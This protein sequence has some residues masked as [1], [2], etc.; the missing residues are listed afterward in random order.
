MLFTVN[1][2]CLDATWGL[3]AIL[4]CCVLVIS[5]WSVCS[6]HRLWLCQLFRCPWS[7]SWFWL[8]LAWN[9]I[10]NM[11]WLRLQLFKTCLAR[12]EH[13]ILRCVKWW[14]AN[15]VNSFWSLEWV[16]M[17]MYSLLEML[18]NLLFSFSL[19]LKLNKFLWFTTE[20]GFILTQ[21]RYILVHIKV[22]VLF[23]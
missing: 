9:Q 21:S 8:I 16:L 15:I 19:F 5:W 6:C 1:C 22:I 14:T 11:W 10:Q 18:I 12:L 4:N 17:R 20:I 13:G 23:R 3:A 2:A 7:L